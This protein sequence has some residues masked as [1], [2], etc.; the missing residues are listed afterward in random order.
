MNNEDNFNWMRIILFCLAILWILSKL[1]NWSLSS[2]VVESNLVLCKSEVFNNYCS[3]PD[4]TL[5]RGYY[6]VIPSRQQV[7]FWVKSDPTPEN[8]S[9]CVVNDMNNWVCDAADGY[10]KVGFENGQYFTE[11][12]IKET[13]VETIQN[14]KR[15]YSVSRLKWVMLKVQE[16]GNNWLTAISEFINL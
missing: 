6:K 9:N 2:N 11:P 13:D 7:M 10:R 14:T 3:S 12:T 16:S 1:F 4:F 8:F 15:T 5:A